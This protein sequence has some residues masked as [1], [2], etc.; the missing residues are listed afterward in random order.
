MSYRKTKFLKVLE[1]IKKGAYF[2]FTIPYGLFYICG[3]VAGY[4]REKSVLCL[5]VSGAIGF[6][7]VLLGA[8]SFGHTWFEN[9]SRP[10]CSRRSSRPYV[11]LHP[12]FLIRNRTHDRLSEDERCDRGILYSDT[13][14]RFN[15]R[16][17][18]N[19]VSLRNRS[20][21]YAIWLRSYSGKKE[22]MS[23]CVLELLSFTISLSIHLV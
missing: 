14:I 7:F 22:F 18:S 4:V 21:F 16:H 5:G 8:S 1:P 17:D 9:Y 19:G 11:V 6:I 12:I 23:I 2:Y 15:D 3:A 10:F 20:Q 13:F